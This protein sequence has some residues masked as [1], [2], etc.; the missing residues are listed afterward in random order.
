MLKKYSLT[1][2]DLPLEYQNWQEQIQELDS[3][4]AVNQFLQQMEAAIN[5]KAQTL[6]Q[7]APHSPVGKN[8]YPLLWLGLGAIIFCAGG[9][10]ILFT[11]SWQKRKISKN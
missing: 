3:N 1:N 11:S 2:Q 6:N 7:T 8:D 10:I 4:Q 9:L 5:K